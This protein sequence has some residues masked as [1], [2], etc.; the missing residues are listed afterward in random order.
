MFKFAD[1]TEKTDM[2]FVRSCMIELLKLAQIFRFKQES[3][4]RNPQTL[5]EAEVLLARTLCFIF[6]VDYTPEFDY[7]SLGKHGLPLRYR[8]KIIKDLNMIELMMELIH[9]PFKNNMYDK[10]DIHKSI[11]AK[12]II[13]LCYTTIRCSIMKYR[14][15][16]LYSSQWLNLLI[17]YSLSSL[18]D[19]IGANSTL[20]EL[21]DNNER[22]LEAQIKKGTIDKFV[23]NL[24]ESRGNKKYIDILR[25]VCI[26]NGKPI[27]ANQKILSEII[28][29]DNINRKKLIPELKM[30]GSEVLIRSPW[31]KETN[32]EWISFANFRNESERMDN[33]RYFSYYSSLMKLLGDLCL[34]RNYIAINVLQSYMT[35]NICIEVICSEEYNWSIRSAFCTLTTNLWINVS[36]FMYIQFPD[37]LKVWSDVNNDQVFIDRQTDGENDALKKFEPLKSFVLKFMKSIK[38]SSQR[39]LVNKFEAYSGFLISI[40]MM[41]KKMILLGF[42][43]KYASFIAIFEALIEILI[44]TDQMIADQLAAEAQD[45]EKLAGK[46]EEN[47]IIETCTDIK[48][49]ICLL[50]KLFSEIKTD[51]RANRLISLYKEKTE[52]GNTKINKGKNERK[53]IQSKHAR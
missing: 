3:N 28:L 48:I 17:E 47:E 7:K 31:V 53:I 30:E 16:E 52:G 5:V 15:N 11:Y 45:S 23:Y 35:L 38:H 8:Q 33:L 40:I 34:N 26:C 21:I 6:D 1:N 43:S 14:P 51:L 50:L 25:A 9:Y 29:K 4:A 18:D 20:T 24:I 22:I 44:T 41:T 2:L 10:K 42:F 37:N 36:P 46:E 19:S 13:Q 32:T 39:N 12:E 27:E 49:K